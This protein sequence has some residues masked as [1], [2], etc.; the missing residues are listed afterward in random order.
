MQDY[1]KDRGDILKELVL[2]RSNQGLIY[3]WECNIIAGFVEG[4]EED[5]ASFSTF[6]IKCLLKLL[7]GVRQSE[8][9]LSAIGNLGISLW[10]VFT[11]EMTD[12]G[13]EIIKAVLPA[14]GRVA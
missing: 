1:Y 2:K 13:P 12:R 11:K 4:G 10:G 3:P 9:L 14:L 6:F 7:A 8:E 5:T